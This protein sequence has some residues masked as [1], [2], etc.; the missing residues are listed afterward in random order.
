MK[1]KIF[2]WLVAV[3]LPTLVF[4]QETEDVVDFDTYASELNAKC[5]IVYNED[6]AINSFSV[7]GDSAI[8]EIRVPEVL[9]AYL[10]LLTGDTAGAKNVW[11]NQMKLFGGQWEDFVDLLVSVGRSLVLRLVPGLSDESYTVVLDPSDFKQ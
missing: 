7:S 5:P 10:P 3:I 2:L 8:V 11:T 6:W 9:E 1:C 4:A